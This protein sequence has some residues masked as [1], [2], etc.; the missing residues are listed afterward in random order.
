M[1]ISQGTLLRALLWNSFRR[2]YRDAS[3]ALY[4]VI[5]GGGSAIMGR[6][7]MLVN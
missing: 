5:K 4:G 6:G 1:S 2:P 3:A 7:R